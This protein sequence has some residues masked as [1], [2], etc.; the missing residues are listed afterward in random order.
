MKYI[1]AFFHRSFLYQSI[2]LSSHHCFEINR[3]HYASK[4][5][6]LWCTSLFSLNCC[7]FI[8]AKIATEAMSEQLLLNAVLMG[9]ICQVSTIIVES[10]TNI[11]ATNERGANACHVCFNFNSY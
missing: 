9:D 2:L 6:V 1:V 8:A 3:G 10:N 4:F 5:V 11:K 7:P